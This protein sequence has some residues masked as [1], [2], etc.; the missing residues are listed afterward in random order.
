MTDENGNV[1]N[2]K[3]FMAFGD[4]AASTQR[5]S[6]GSGNNYDTSESRQDY[7]GYEKDS[8]SGLEFAQARY[9]SSTQGRYTSVDPMT[10]SATIRNPQSFNRYSYVLNSPYKFTDPLGLLPEWSP[11]RIVEAG[12][13]GPR[14]HT[15]ELVYDE[16]APGSHSNDASSSPATSGTSNDTSQNNQPVANQLAPPPTVDENAGASA[17]NDPPKSVEDIVNETF[18]DGAIWH[19]HNPDGSSGEPIAI[20]DGNAVR[21]QVLPEAQGVYN[22]SVA[23]GIN[24]QI[25]ENYGTAPTG[26]DVSQQKADVDARIANSANKIG[27]AI[28]KT[29]ITM[30][31][32]KASLVDKNP[33]TIHAGIFPVAARA[34]VK[35]VLERVRDQGISQGRSLVPDPVV[36]LPPRL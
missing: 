23:L 16:V 7:T 17:S 32:P 1:T 15:Y 14:D 35:G 36:F 11:T 31:D 19:V 9:Y 33:A 27:D 25:Q 29:G 24:Q 34:A 28:S 8:E 13:S 4:Q 12:D 3:D 2:R 26:A 10:G 18:G 30:R 22:Q 21:K 6:G 20:A 5:V